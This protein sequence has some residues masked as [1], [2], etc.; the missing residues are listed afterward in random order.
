MAG[1]TGVTLQKVIDAINT[2]QENGT[3][4]DEDEISD[5]T[6]FEVDP[7]AHNFLEI[8]LKYKTY[9]DRLS[10]IAET[11]KQ[12]Q[13]DTDISNI[14]LEDTKGFLS[15]ED[16]EILS[17]KKPNTLYGAMRLGM[18]PTAIASIYFYLKK[19]GQQLEAV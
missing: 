16:F 1:F 18:K 17:Q 2:Y 8:E 3:Y 7:R 10:K 14:N 6:K 9:N 11:L 4:T 19:K 15:F 12:E 5:T 13:Y